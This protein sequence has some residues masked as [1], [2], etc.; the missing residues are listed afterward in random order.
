MIEV[1]RISDKNAVQILSKGN[2]KQQYFYDGNNLYKEPETIT[3]TRDKK[4][5]DRRKNYDEYINSYVVVS[6]NDL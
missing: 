1:E 4:N 2:H 5:E 6:H 3:S